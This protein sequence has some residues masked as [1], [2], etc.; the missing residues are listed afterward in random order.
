MIKYIII[1][2]IMFFITLFLFITAL[3]FITSLAMIE[4]WSYPHPLINDVPTVY[5]EYIQYIKGI[6]TEWHWGYSMKGEIHVMD[7]LKEKMSFTMTVIILTLIIYIPTGIL[8]GI[9]SAVKKNTKIDKI[10]GLFTLIFGSIPSFVL[11]FILIYY[12]GYILEW[13]PK[14]Y[15]PDLH[16]PK[17]RL[18]GFI[19][20]IL[21]LSAGPLS[22][23]TRVVRGEL[24]DDFESNYFLVLKTKGLSRRQ[25]IF[26]HSLKN[27]IVSILPVILSSFIFVLCSSFF[28]EI[29]YGIPGIAKQLFY[30]IFPFGIGTEI[31]IDIN[32]LVLIATF[33]TAISLLVGLIIDFLYGVFDPRIKFVSKK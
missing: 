9:I 33:Y 23:I 16:G 30:S 15:P 1:R 21:A 7:I 24:I 17:A 19:I 11:I 4:L 25:S 14:Q 10:I 5:R 27:C 6:F 22:D 18:L 28:I 12:F 20:P 32:R 8:L 2:I 26:R 31:I 3:Y 29:I 13:L